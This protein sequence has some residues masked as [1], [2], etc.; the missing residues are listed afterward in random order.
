[1]TASPIANL[2]SI[3]CRNEGSM[4]NQPSTCEAAEVGDSFNARTCS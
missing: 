2:D 1:M 4:D 3:D